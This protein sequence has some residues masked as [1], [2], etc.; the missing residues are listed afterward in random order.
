M[1]L[2]I[3]GATGVLGRRL[4]KQLVA[5][6]HQVVGLVRRPEN[7]PL[8]RSLGAEPR[9]ADLFDA[10]SLA[11]V[12]AGCEVV[13]HAATAIPTAAKY[14][15][16]DWAM[17][18]RIR[19][20]GTRALAE[21]AGHVGARAFLFQ[22][23]IWVAR[24][25]D[26][27][28]FDEDSPVNPGPQYQSSVDGENIT[29]EAAAQHGFAASILRC[30]AFYSADAAH[31][32]QFADLLRARKLPII[33]DGSNRWSMIHADDAASA[34]V[35]A[36]ESPRNG[37]WHAVD[38]EPVAVATFLRE[39]ARLIGAPPP[40]R[41]PVWL[42]R[43]LAGQMTTEYMT[44]NNMTSNACFKRDFGWQPRYPAYREGLTEVAEQIR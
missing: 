20:E 31:V 43:L 12:A 4:V 14:D 1:K 10:D 3:A 32:R 9:P 15:P 26:H 37:L 18:D 36:A 39:F 21:A 35:T 42:A 44:A 16:A 2:F 13:I 38:D 17:N 29:R 7:E 28:P 5:R 8:L 11:R 30:G 33:G 34:F 27:S 6:G 41:V 22:S 23:I 24:P 19:R 25:P 40:R